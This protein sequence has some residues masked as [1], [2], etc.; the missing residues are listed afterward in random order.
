MQQHLTTETLIDYLHAELDSASDAAALAHLEAC[1]QCTA[2]FESETTFG[3]RLR[4]NARREALELPLGFQSA[5]IARLAD[6][7]SPMQRLAAFWRP[8]IFVPVAAAAAVA[9]FVLLPLAHGNQGPTGT[10]LPASYY[11]EEHAAQVRGNPMA[12]RSATSAMIETSF[13]RPTAGGVPIGEAA[14]ASTL[15]GDA[16]R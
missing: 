12:D 15:A 5:I 8:V 14:N 1:A 7:Q 9:A 13:E 2:A 4:T 16:T 3:E 6:H 10:L 11:L